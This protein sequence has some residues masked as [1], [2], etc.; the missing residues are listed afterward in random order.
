MP[1][2]QLTQCTF[3][4]GTQAI[5][6]DFS[7]NL[8]EGQ[9]WLVTGPSGSGKTTIFKALHGEYR[10][11]G[12]RFVFKGEEGPETFEKLKA[13]AGFVFF[14]DQ[15]IDPK[16]FYYQQRYNS[17]DADDTLT[18]SDYLF[19]GDPPKE[20]RQTESLHLFHVEEHMDKEFIKLS[21]GENRKVLITKALLKDPKILVLDNPYTGLDEASRIDLNKLIDRLAQ[22]GMTILLTSK[23]DHIPE[24]MTHVLHLENRIITYAG[25]RSSATQAGNTIQTETIPFGFPP[26]ENNDFDIVVR[27][28]QV[29]IRYEEKLLL[30]RIDLTIRRGEKWLLKGPN[31]AGKSLIASLIYADHPQSY[32]ND[33]T[34]F[35]RPRGRGESI[36][37]IKDRIGFLSPEY[38]FYFDLAWTAQQVAT[39]GLKDNPYAPK[40]LTP[41]TE[42]MVQNLF[43]YYGIS[44]LMDQPM[45]ALSTGFQRLVL[46]I[47]VLVKNPPFLLLDEPFQH[48]DRDTIE[49]SK[50][51][52]DAFCADRTLLFITH[53]DSEVPGIVKKGKRMEL[54]A[55]KKKIL[56]SQRRRDAKNI[57]GVS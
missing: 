10:L 6:S 21:N 56:L 1:L 19:D 34:L 43:G 11:T 45:H 52:L 5:L 14:Q 44:H 20:T 30:D 18:V 7:W 25:I 46:F 13:S 4:L 53:E 50:V 26:L 39:G 22:S 51:L 8:E 32:M 29:T 49:K 41:E 23:Q 16:Q 55:P 17:Q 54:N 9:Q 2:I 38:H 28:N 31:G 3:C 47:R 15:A 48:F 42:Q 27:L 24:R 57:N 36:W 35:D 12:G 37:E 33:I 40:A